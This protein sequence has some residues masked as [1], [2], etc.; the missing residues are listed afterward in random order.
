M[1][2]PFIHSQILLNTL[3]VLATELIVGYCCCKYLCSHGT[4]NLVG[5]YTTNK[6]TII[7]IVDSYCNK[8][9]FIWWFRL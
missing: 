3:Y 7:Y 9:F 5:K 2:F 1:L 6:Q 8:P 4:Y